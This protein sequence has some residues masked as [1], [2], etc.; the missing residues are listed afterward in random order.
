MRSF[1]ATM[2]QAARIYLKPGKEH[3]LQRKHPWVFSGAIGRIE[4]EPQDGDTVYV[5]SAKGDSLGTGHY[6]LGSIAVRIFAFEEV[7]ADET[8][9]VKKISDA[10]LL[11]GQL[12][13]LDNP[14]TNMFRLVHGEGDGMPGCIID[15]Y[16][17]TAVIQTHTLGMYRHREVI[18]QAIVKAL[19]N[20]VNVYDRGKE[21][22]GQRSNEKVGSYLI[23]QAEG[24][25]GLEH[26]CRFLIDWE[27]GQKTG[28]FLDQRENR[29][30]LGEMSK[31]KR[32]LN[33][34]CYTGGFSIY[35]LRHGALEV[36]SLDSSQPALDLAREH[37]SINGFDER[38]H[39]TICADAVS[40]MRDLNESYDIIVLD[41]PAF[42]KNV[43]A[44][45]KA[46][47]AYIRINA[48]AMRNVK[49][50][51][52]LFT[53]SCSQVIDTKL[54]RDSVM[55]AGIQA[56]RTMRIT[57]QLHQ[58]ADHPVSLFHP[59]GEYLKGL[60]IQIL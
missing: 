58:P 53:F 45:H 12:G 32:V 59:E 19:P 7:Q 10:A 9:W 48:A 29:K 28:F 55:A 54:F 36:H 41:P 26:G 37:A 11:R 30:L 20:V 25:D 22:I 8:F 18:A 42:A 43:G 51:G 34:F 31:G 14:E 35:A 38:S 60:V 33:T 24:M 23:G 17:H 40:Y 16:G 21:K 27:Q 47:Q 2:E 1:A 44:K 15:I 5:Y 49:S 50:G 3:S 39:K 52:F 57:H 13:F 56:G 46:I 6:A 4:G